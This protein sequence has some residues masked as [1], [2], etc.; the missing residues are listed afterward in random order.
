MYLSSASLCSYWGDDSA[1]VLQIQVGTNWTLEFVR[2]YL[3]IFVAHFPYYPTTVG[4]L[5]SKSRRSSAKAFS[6]AWSTINSVPTTI[7]VSTSP[8]NKVLKASVG[9][10]PVVVSAVVLSDE[11][12]ACLLV[13]PQCDSRQQE[14]CA[15]CGVGSVYQHANLCLGCITRGHF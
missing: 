14:L 6:F 3:Q 1:A 10:A 8:S 12:V 7:V 15:R 5:T 2:S 13:P 11:E 4:V 9:L